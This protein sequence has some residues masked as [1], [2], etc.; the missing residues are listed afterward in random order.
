MWIQVAIAFGMIILLNELTRV[1][2]L[3]IFIA[4]LLIILIANPACFATMTAWL[5]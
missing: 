3:T 2:R 4:V 1:L 5:R